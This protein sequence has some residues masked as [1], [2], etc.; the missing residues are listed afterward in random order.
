M[1]DTWTW[2]GVSEGTVSN[3]LLNGLCLTS[4]DNPCSGPSM[5]LLKGLWDSAQHW[6]FP[7]V[8]LMA[9]KHTCISLG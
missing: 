1:V 9:I 7:Y 6:S 4:P 8:C 3:Q 5:D 2:E